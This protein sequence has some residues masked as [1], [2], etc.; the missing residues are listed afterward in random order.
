LFSSAYALFSSSTFLWGL[1]CFCVDQAALE[2]QF[3]KGM[4]IYVNFNN[5]HGRGWVPGPVGHNRNV[6]SNNAAMLSL[7][8]FEFGKE[9]G[10]TLMF[11]ALQVALSILIL[12][13]SIFD[14]NL[15]IQSEPL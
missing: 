2:G 5:F 13:D 7:D 15:P 9:R 6:T 1:A 4:P 3:Y 11:V 10:A 14:A 12:H 8:W